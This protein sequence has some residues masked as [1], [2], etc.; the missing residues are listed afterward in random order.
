MSVIIGLKGPEQPELSALELEK[1]AILDGFQH[2]LFITYFI[3]CQ[4]HLASN[5]DIE[6]ISSC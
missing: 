4:N 1:I 3:L 5:F 6:Y 2:F